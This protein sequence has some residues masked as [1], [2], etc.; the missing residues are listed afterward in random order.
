MA[1]INLG[2]SIDSLAQDWINSNVPAPSAYG[3]TLTSLSSDITKWSQTCGNYVHQQN[4]THNTANGTSACQ[5]KIN[6]MYQGLTLQLQNEEATKIRNAENPVPP[7]NTRLYEL[8]ALVV[9]IMIVVVLIL[10]M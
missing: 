10:K 2:P 7:D 4:F 3:G 8:I 5:G 1:I 9:I 6:N